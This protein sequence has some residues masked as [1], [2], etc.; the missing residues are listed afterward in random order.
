MTTDPGHV[1]FAAWWD[2]TAAVQHAALT[3]SML[4][5]LLALNLLGGAHD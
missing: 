1:L 5:T 3:V 2:A 4:P